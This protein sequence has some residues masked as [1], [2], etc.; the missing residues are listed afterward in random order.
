MRTL[1]PVLFLIAHTA[2]AANLPPPVT[3]EQPISDRVFIAAAGDQRTL[4]VASDGHIGF[5]VWLDARR[6][7]ADLFGSRIDANGVSLDSL[8]IFI[9]TNTSGG[10]VIWNGSQFVVVSAQGRDTT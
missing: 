10:S 2:A 8:G 4:A 6:G 7:R 5:A 9:S 3:P 1:V